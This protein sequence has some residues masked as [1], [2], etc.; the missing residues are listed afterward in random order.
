MSAPELYLDT[1]THLDTHVLNWRAPGS[2]QSL[3]GGGAPSTWAPQLHNARRRDADDTHGGR[4]SSAADD[5]SNVIV[6]VASVEC[7]HGG[8]GATGIARLGRL[9]VVVAAAAA[10]RAAEKGLLLQERAGR[11]SESA[12]KIYARPANVSR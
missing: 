2:P 4:L 12:H 3:P 8:L 7:V 11:A 6:L 10:T 9:V 5:P 1:H